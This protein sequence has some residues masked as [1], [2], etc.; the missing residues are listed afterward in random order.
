MQ[1]AQPCPQTPVQMVLLQLKLKMLLY[2][3][4][5]PKY[6]PS[7]NSSPHTDK[8]STIP[9]LSFDDSSAS[10]M[11]NDRRR[12]RGGTMCGHSWEERR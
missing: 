1:N 4:S 12:T 9:D 5:T 11:A 6:A 2:R 7:F 3:R 8:R 10:L